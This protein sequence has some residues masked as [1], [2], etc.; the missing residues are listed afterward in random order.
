MAKKG[1]GR[2]LKSLLG[3]EDIPKESSDIISPPK[4]ENDLPVTEIKLSLIEPN[5]KQP[6]KKFD[7]EKLE[8][9]SESIS[10][11]GV[12]QPIIITPSDNGMYTIIAGERRWRAA[13][14]AGLKQ[15]PAIVR[16]YSEIEA[17]QIALIENLQREDLNPI[18]EAAGYRS[19]MDEF[20]LT[21]EDISKRIG[22]SRSAIANSLRLLSLG[23]EIS[24]LLVSGA[25]STGHARAL[26]SLE[27]EE[28]RLE[29]AQIIIND[30]L[31]VRQTEKLVK[32]LSNSRPKRPAPEVDELLM[33]QLEEISQSLRD[34]F[35]TNVTIT[36]GAKKGRIEIEYYS[37]D[38]LDR[39]I[40]LLQG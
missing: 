32:K 27:N 7:K 16:D 30:G 1:L 5:R 31:N 39:I 23:D 4:G 35:G 8:A 37:S 34:K 28:L 33:V 15:I 24:E 3:T 12:I 9:L 11:H 40:G 21:Q 38:D 6:R 2:G 18:E 25:L 10:E 14:K 19:L 29:A 26:L 22:K 13:K 17:A 36:N 20:S